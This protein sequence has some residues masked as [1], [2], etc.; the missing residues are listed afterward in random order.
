MSGTRRHRDDV[1]PIA[2]FALPVAVVSGCEDS[3]E[4]RDSDGVVAARGQRHRVFPL[5]D[6]ARPGRPVPGRKDPPVAS[7]SDGVQITGRDGREVVPIVDDALS[8]AIVSR[9]PN[10]RARPWSRSRL[11]LKARI[12][13]S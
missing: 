4:R 1:L 12:R 7:E 9:G 11:A 6:V 3:S 2:D 10:L 5:I 13:C 8:P